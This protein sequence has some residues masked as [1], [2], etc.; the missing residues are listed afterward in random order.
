[1]GIMGKGVRNV[2]GH[3]VKGRQNWETCRQGRRWAGTGMAGSRQVKLYKLWGK[4]KGRVGKAQ[5]A[6]TG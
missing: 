3:R 2:E 1:M 5:E 6:G 4:C